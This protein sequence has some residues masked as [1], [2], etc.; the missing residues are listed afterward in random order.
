MKKIFILTVLLSFTNLFSQDFWIQTN[1]PYGGSPNV[2]VTQFNGS[3]F[4]GTGMGGGIYKSTNNAISWEKKL[5][6]IPVIGSYSLAVDA[7][8]FLYAG[9]S[10]LIKSTDGGNTWIPFSNYTYGGVLNIAFN[11]NGDI[12][13]SNYGVLYRSTNNGVNWVI[14]ETMGGLTPGFVIVDQNNILYLGL[15]G[16]WIQKS[17]SNGNNW[18][19]IPITG[20]GVG[21]AIDSSG[22][23]LV[24]NYF[25][26]HKSTNGGLN[27][28]VICNAGNFCSISAVSSTEL[29]AGTAYSQIF[30]SSD[31]GQTWNEVYNASIASWVRGIVRLQNGNILA[32]AWHI[33]MLKSTNGGINW[34]T[35]NTGINNQYTSD[36]EYN[37]NG[38]LYCGTYFDGIYMTSNHGQSWAQMGLEHKYVGAIGT[39]GDNYVFA[40][41]NGS[42]EMYRS[43][44]AGVNWHLQDSLRFHGT[45]NFLTINTVI[46]AG[47][48]EGILRSTDLGVDWQ[49]IAFSNS[50]MLKLDKDSSNG[51]YASTDTSVYYSADYGNS[52]TRLST[53]LQSSIR[54]MTISQANN[55]IYVVSGSNLYRSING[56]YNWLIVSGNLYFNFMLCNSEG[57]IFG[58]YAGDVRRSTDFGV[59]WQL[60]NSGLFNQYTNE[61]GIDGED[62]LYISTSGSG[63]FRSGAPT[64]S[65]SQIN[66]SLPNNFSLFQNYPNPF[67]PIT[68]IKFDIPSK[69]KSQTSNVK[70]I[71]YDVLGREVAVLVNEELRAGSYETEWDGTSFPSGVYFYRITTEKYSETKKMVL[72]K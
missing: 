32:T 49:T 9:P 29:Y 12:F 54:C 58:S 35:Y 15:I 28:Q 68:K 65:V 45:S 50:R 71:V 10:S 23:L 64:V 7:N 26:I 43:S 20:G 3:I 13:A 5:N 36:I 8:N 40:N 47:T 57:T 34:S 59:S 67:N 62:Y 46:F 21:M 16:G 39:I 38:R 56:G 17:T 42:G 4:C 53:F 2:I 63:I 11:S 69:V 18:T 37:G 44:D 51:I 55:Y 41:I 1:G 24:A 33:G 22:N 27:W 25:G 60:L 14:I 52:W 31:N 30:R 66:Y 72:L 70:I 6:P 19:H 61:L 48:W